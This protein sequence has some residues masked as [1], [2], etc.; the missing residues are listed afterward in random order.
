M[1]NRMSKQNKEK[2]LKSFFKLLEEKPYSEITIVDIS[3]DASVSRKTFYRL[4]K[5]KENLLNTYIDQLL[6][7]WVTYANKKNPQN[8]EDLITLL[9]EFWK[10]YVPQLTILVN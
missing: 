7:D 5:N 6:N 2:I 10:R 4:F 9:F 3:I 1:R 8:Y